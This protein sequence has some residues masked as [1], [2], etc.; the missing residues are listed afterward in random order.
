MKNKKFKHYIFSGKAISGKFI[1]SGLILLISCS[2]LMPILFGACEKFEEPSV[3]Y[4]TSSKPS[5]SNDPVISQV[6]PPNIATAGVAGRV[7]KINGKNIGVKNGTDTDWVYIGGKR[8]IIK[9]I[10]QNTMITIARPQLTDDKYGKKIVLSVTDPKAIDTSANVEYIIESPGALLGDYV[11]I[12]AVMMGVDLDKNENIFI[13][14]GR[15]VWRNDLSGV[16]LTQML[17]TSSL[18]GDFRGTTDARFGPGSPGEVLHVAVGKNYLYSVRVDT[19]STSVKAVKGVTL[20]TVVNKLDF[21]ADGNIYAGGSEGIFKINTADGSVSANLGFNGTVIKEIHIF[22]GNIYIADS[23]RIWK[24]SLGGSTLDQGAPVIDLT[25]NSALNTCRINSFAIDEFGNLYL[26]LRNH[27][28]YS[29][30]VVEEN[31]AITPF[32]DDENILPNTIE[33][34]IWADSGNL[35][36]ISNSLPGATAGVYASNRIFVMKMDRKGAPYQGRKFLP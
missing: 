10:V 16:T 19:S 24:S 34:L 9:E 23:V 32:Y 25:T 15:Q 31:G 29:L 4:D 11:N 22:N 5:T 12:T 30:F 18:V 2:I 6:P 14:A 36:L 21:D 7:I 17:G 33:Q 1:F 27:P 35:Y 3:I 20:P 26:S 13:V 8:A 28:K